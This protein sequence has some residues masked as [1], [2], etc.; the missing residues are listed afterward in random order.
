MVL[1][2]WNILDAATIC[3]L[4]LMAFHRRRSL[5]SSRT[6]GELLSLLMMF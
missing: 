5:K 3:Q 1:L 6:L 2:L 4:D